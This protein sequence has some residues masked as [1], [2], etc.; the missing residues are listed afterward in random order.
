ML[1]KLLGGRHVI[2]WKPELSEKLLYVIAQFFIAFA[3][4]LSSSTTKTPTNKNK[5][6]RKPINKIQKKNHRRNRYTHTKLSISGTE[7]W[8]FYLTKHKL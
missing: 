1:R 8:V 2:L 3:L 6:I 7:T 5:K 4:S